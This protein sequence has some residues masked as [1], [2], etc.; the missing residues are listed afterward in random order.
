[1]ENFKE[2]I[3]TTGE[4]N[5]ENT[6]KFIIPENEITEQSSRSSGAGGQ[7]VNKRSTK[8]EVRWNVDAST[9]FTDEEKEG[10]KQVL[11]NKITK[12][13]D[14]IVRSQEERSWLQNK[15]RAIERLNNLVKWALE[16]EKDRIPTEPTKSSKKRRLEDKKRQGEKKKQRSEKP[17][18]N[19]Y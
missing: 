8:S 10:I 18:I 13:W 2:K 7:N 12:E 9:A 15:E 6:Q 4:E 11:G 1:L 5:M 3:K 17:K 16:T 19:D 14:L